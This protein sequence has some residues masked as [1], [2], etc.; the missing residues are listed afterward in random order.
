MKK[1]SLF[2]YAGRLVLLLVLVGCFALSGCGLK[3]DPIPDSSSEAFGFEELSA[4]MTV[5][6]VLT[7]QGQISGASRNLDYLILE[8]QPV[9]DE[10]CLG[11]PF[12][13]QEQQRFDSRDIWADLF[14]KNF[15]FV[16]APAYPAAAYRWRLVGRNV[17]A[18]ISETV[19]EI[20]VV[21]RDKVDIEGG[22][23]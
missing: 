12:L 23:L 14:G 2:V 1:G 3:G 16:F 15:S 5:D 4:E 18:G 17:F 7:F 20:Q 10:L 22:R 19:S 13:A 9:D 8:I 6:G 11:C 21:G